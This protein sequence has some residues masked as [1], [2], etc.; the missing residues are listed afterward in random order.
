M[1]FVHLRHDEG[2]AVVTIDRPPANALDPELIADGLAALDTLLRDRPKA[3]V[4]T[5]SGRFFSGGADLRVVPALAQEEQ[6]EMAG[7]VNRLFAGWHRFPRPLVT[8]VN[9]HAVAGGLILA[10]CGD[11]RVG[12]TSGRFGLTEVK[13]GIPFPSMAMAVVQAELAP[14]V[15]RRLVLG[16]E[17]VDAA[18]AL[19][20][21]I[22]DELAADGAV[23]DRA[24]A[25]A[26]TL[27]ELPPATYEVVKHRLRA[28]TAPAAKAAG[29]ASSA[30]WVTDEAVEAA[31]S[32]LDR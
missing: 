19:E 4:I 10:L 5:G 27:A 3:A 16:S 20:L 18:T 31:R 9:G 12:P 13:V 28:T 8:A 17:L 23:L 30:G 15:A 22:F 11:Y 7:D 25:V 26:R 2:V 1:R 21:G 24:L 32:V 14:G 6:A 29:R